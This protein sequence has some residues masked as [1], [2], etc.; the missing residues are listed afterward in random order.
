MEKATN[1]ASVATIAINL[2]KKAFQFHVIDTSDK[3]DRD[4][5]SAR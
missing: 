5:P 4:P 1:R 3:V 2:A